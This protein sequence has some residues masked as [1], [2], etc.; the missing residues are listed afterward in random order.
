MKTVAQA[1][2]AILDPI[3]TDNDASGAFQD[4]VPQT[5]PPQT[6]PRVIFSLENDLD[7]NDTPQRARD[8]FV[9]V[10]VISAASFAQ[11]DDIQALIDD[12]L[13]DVTLTIDGYINYSTKRQNA[14]PR[15]AETA[16]GG[17]KYYHVG[18]IYN[19]QIEKEH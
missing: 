9:I 14:A 19:V 2:K 17:A 3:V 4:D 12:A 15:L 11:A 7:L 6:F 18:G 10:K 16:A 5:S 13:H 8:I 1:I